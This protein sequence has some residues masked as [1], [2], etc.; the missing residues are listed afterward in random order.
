MQ[1]ILSESISEILCENTC[2]ILDDQKTYKYYDVS[3]ILGTFAWW[4]KGQL[5]NAFP[6]LITLE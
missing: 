6:S 1:K 5:T 4:K 3:A 2:V